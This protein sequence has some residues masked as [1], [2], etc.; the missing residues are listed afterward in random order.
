MPCHLLL[1]RR[2]CLATLCCEEICCTATPPKKR[3]PF[4]KDVWKLGVDYGD[5]LG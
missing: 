3:E 4:L 1:Q 2:A 5:L